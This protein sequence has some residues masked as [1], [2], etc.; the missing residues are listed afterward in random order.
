M[1]RFRTSNL[2]FGTKTA[3]SFPEL[4]DHAGKLKT[5]IFKQ[6]TLL[7]SPRND[8]LCYLSKFY[9]KN[10]LKTVKRNPEKVC[11]LQLRK[12]LIYCNNKIL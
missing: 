9:N 2:I 8:G 3:T 12:F 6:P 10:S 11:F 5:V 7:K 1:L 4:C